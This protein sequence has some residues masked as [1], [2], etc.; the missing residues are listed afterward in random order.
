MITIDTELIYKS[1]YYGLNTKRTNPNAY[2]SIDSYPEER[3]LEGASGNQNL[4]SGDIDSDEIIKA[5]KLHLPQ[6]RLAILKMLNHS[7][8]VDLLYLLEKGGLALGLKFFTKEKL[9]N[10]IYDLPKQEILKILFKVY[11]KDDFLQMMPTKALM[12]FLGSSKIQHRE[13]LK[14]MEGMPKHLLAQ[15]LESVTE[16]CR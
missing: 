1:Q 6:N 13:L 16:A 7:E 12:A 11:S 3:A 15:I 2:K 8:L 10:N 5:L 4:K 9:L 14:A